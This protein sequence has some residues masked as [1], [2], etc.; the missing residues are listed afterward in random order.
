MDKKMKALLYELKDWAQHQIPI[1]L[2]S[3]ENTII[4]YNHY[5]FYETVGPNKRLDIHDNKYNHI[6][7]LTIDMINEHQALINCCRYV[8]IPDLNYQVNNGKL[9]QFV[10]IVIK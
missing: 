10:S 7:T 3:L 8:K 9:S 4:G 6:A 2:S 5:Y 1:T